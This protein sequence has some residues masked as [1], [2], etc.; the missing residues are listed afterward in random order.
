MNTHV[1]FIENSR[2][3]AELIVRAILQKM[4]VDLVS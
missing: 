3:H 1:W 2:V 4:A